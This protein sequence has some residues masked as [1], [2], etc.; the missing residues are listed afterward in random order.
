MGEVVVMRYEF[1]E[2]NSLIVGV[3]RQKESNSSCKINC[4]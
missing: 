2:K 3:F 4:F 1:S